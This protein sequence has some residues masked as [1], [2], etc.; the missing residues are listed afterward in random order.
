MTAD[1][2][3]QLTALGAA[4]TP[5]PWYVRHLDDDT[6]QG[7]VAVSTRRDTGRDE[8]MRSGS[9][10][11]SEIVAACLIQSPPYVAPAD[12]RF[13]ENAALIAALR[14]ALAELIRLARVGLASEA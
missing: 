11:T 2:L 6:R 4:G 14:N 10:P 7:A 8:D 13:E 1:E 12:D 3:D 5:A 9:W